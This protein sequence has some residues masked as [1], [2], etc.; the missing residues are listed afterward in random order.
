MK[1]KNTP[2]ALFALPF[3]ALSCANVANEPQALDAP[4]QAADSD[5]QAM[6]DAAVLLIERGQLMPLA[7]SLRSL[8]HEPDPS[9][10]AA[11]IE[12]VLRSR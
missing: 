12:R 10:A 6:A 5:L 7:D 3:L 8:G 1:P 2:L 11:A 9:E 4:A